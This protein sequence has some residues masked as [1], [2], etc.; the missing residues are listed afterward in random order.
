MFESLGSLYAFF[1]GDRPPLIRA[2]QVRL[3]AI[4]QY[5]ALAAKT[6]FAEGRTRAHR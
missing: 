6:L 5:S 4:F 1:P 3:S 2:R